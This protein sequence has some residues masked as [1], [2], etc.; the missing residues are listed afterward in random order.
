MLY[1]TIFISTASNSRLAT[2]LFHL[3]GL[4]KIESDSDRRKS[5]RLA[6]IALPAL[7]CLFYLTVGKPVT[8]ITVGAVAQALMLPFLSFAALYF[9]YKKTAVS[10]R[11]KRAWIVLLWI[12]ALLMTSVGIFQI[13]KQIA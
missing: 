11:P 7:Y 5:I 9:L 2:D 10:L 13:L 12:S 3:L 8:L 1:S 4:V 6:C